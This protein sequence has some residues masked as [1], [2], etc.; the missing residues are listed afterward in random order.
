MLGLRI[1]VTTGGRRV[2]S[3][4]ASAIASNLYCSI[5]LYRNELRQLGG[6]AAAA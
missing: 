4:T 5:D 1:D 3:N 6:H 2:N